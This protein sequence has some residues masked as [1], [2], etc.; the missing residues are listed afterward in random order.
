MRASA[1]ALFTRLFYSLLT[2]ARACERLLGRN[3]LLSLW[4]VSIRAQIANTCSNCE[5]LAR[6]V[7]HARYDD[8][9]IFWR[10]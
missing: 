5:P 9:K 3:R 1:R 7:L 4:L 10:L 8:E 6:V 2:K